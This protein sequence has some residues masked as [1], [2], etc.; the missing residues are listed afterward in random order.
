MAG[1]A[2]TRPVGENPRVAKQKSSGVADSQDPRARKTR[3][4]IAAAFVAILGRRSYDRIRVSDIT[5]KSAVGRATFYAHFASKDALL[6]AELGR[7]ALPLVT[8]SRHGPCPVDA[9]AL[10]A[11]VHHARDIYRSLLGGAARG[12]TERIVREALES[13]IRDVLEADGEAPLTADDFTSRFVSS[14]L[15]TLLAWSLERDPP[16]SPAELQRRFASLVGPALA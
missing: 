8:S 2:V 12:L 10:F 13:R 6:R 14:T 4:A 7:V 15:L 16:P 3:A 5:R 11:H 1:T 9:T